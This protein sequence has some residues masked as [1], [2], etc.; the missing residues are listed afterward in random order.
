MNT[1]TPRILWVSWE[2]HRRT[3][4]LA[5]ALDVELHVV[6]RPDRPRIRRYLSSARETLR[7]VHRSRPCVLIV[8]SPSLVLG[9]LAL[10]LGRWYRLPVVQDAH[11]AAIRPEAGL[12]SSIRRAAISLLVSQMRV[13]VVTNLGLASEV[14]RMGGRPCVLPDAIPEVPPTKSACAAPNSVL[15]ICT[16]ADDEPFREF[17]SAA[18]GLNDLGWRVFMT[19]RKEHMPR[20]LGNVSHV[21]L[22]GFVPEEG[23][24][25]LLKSV[26]VV[27]DLTTR[28]DCLVCG[29]YEALAAGTPMLLSDTQ[30]QRDYFRGAARYTANSPD[31]IRK[32]LLALLGDTETARADAAAARRTIEQDWHRAAADFRRELSR[33]ADAAAP[34]W[35]REGQ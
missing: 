24:W 22:T 21:T 12:L 2:Q 1:E 5:R 15:Y 35:P 20:D 27:V 33:L 25:T 3:A 31:A 28:T 11:N 17:L 9:L 26:D 23:Y 18:V 4:E 13:T 19:G 8:Q 6:E 16:F 10:A 14:E 32:N 30:A 7:V 29:A 34:R